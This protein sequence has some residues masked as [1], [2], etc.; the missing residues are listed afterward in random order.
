MCVLWTAPYGRFLPPGCDNHALE[1]YFLLLLMLQARLD[2]ADEEIP[3]LEHK[4]LEQRLAKLQQ[5]IDETAAT[6]RVGQLMQ[7]GLQV[8]W[9]CFSI[10]EEQLANILGCSC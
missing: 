8:W 10:F 5:D 9:S 1:L 3:A 6:A 7:S 2:F 4:V